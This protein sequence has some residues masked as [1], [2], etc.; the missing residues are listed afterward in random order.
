MFEWCV[1]CVCVVLVVS[2]FV[3]CDCVRCVFVVCVWCVY[4]VC[5]R[6]LDLRLHFSSCNKY[7]SSDTK[8]NYIVVKFT[9]YVYSHAQT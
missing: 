9:K 8:N 4:V 1:G 3:W 2:V 6:A 7:V 5:V